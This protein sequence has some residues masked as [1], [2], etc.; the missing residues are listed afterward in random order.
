MIPVSVPPSFASTLQV[1][2]L[3]VGQGDS[4]VITASS[5]EVVMIDSGPDEYSHPP[6]AKSS[7]HISY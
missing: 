2:Y 5:G 1:Y 3:D 6:E 7:E 4:I